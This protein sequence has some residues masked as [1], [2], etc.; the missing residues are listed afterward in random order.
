MKTSLAKLL[1]TALLC[2]VASSAAWA[3]HR[4]LLST[5]FPPMHPIYKDVLQPWAAEVK[6]ATRGGVLIEF[7]PNSLAPPPGQLDMVTQGVADVT[8][9]FSG[10]VPRRLTTMLITEM[11]GTVTTAEAMSVALWRTHQRFFEKAD[12]HG[13]VKLLS[14]VV[15][16]PQGFF[17]TRPEPF[18]NLQQLKSA[19][20]ATTP[21]T[22]ARTFGAVTSGVVAGP[23]VRYF[24]L[25]SKGTVDA[26]AS[27]SALDVVGFN[28]LR[29]TRTSTRL[30]NLMGA[31]SF[32]LVM[33]T[34]KWNALSPTQQE[35]ITRLSGEYFARR[36][37]ALDEAN[38]KSLE[39]LRQAS[40]V[41][42]DAPA[43]LQQ[44][45][46]RNF[47]FVEKD[48]IGQVAERGVDGAA[49]LAFYREEQRRI[50]AGR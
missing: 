48:W 6:E 5:F 3:Q 50:L 25:V 33:N 23:A 1:S 38:A 19:K 39:A 18:V 44:E 32:S 2:L 35:A 41:F 28:L 26:Y 15:F 13:R 46:A 47:A 9:Q 49:A 16:P 11:P 45:L 43:E 21:G 30:S 31:A 22:L 14:M 36:M 34:G 4:L 42:V 20:I 7:S 12:E 17:G 29:H 27:V 37:A 40:V 8:L 24:E 10:V